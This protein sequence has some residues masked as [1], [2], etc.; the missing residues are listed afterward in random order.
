MLR[1]LVLRLLGSGKVRTSAAF[2]VGAVA[3]AVANLLFAG[4]LSP[5]AYGTLALVVAIIAAGVPI[6]PFGVAVVVVR[7][8]LS[9]ERSL[10]LRCAFT[11]TLVGFAVAIIA[12]YVYGLA[13]ALLLVIA[14]TIIGG[15]FTRIVAARLQSEER[16]LAS[17]LVS[18]GGNYVLLIAAVGTL[19]LNLNGALLPLAFVGISQLLLAA[20][21]AM[22]LVGTTPVQTPTH[23]KFPFWEML[24]L[25]GTNAATMVLLQLER[26]AIPVLLDVE[27]LATFAVLAVFT[28]APFRPVEVSTYRTLLP[29]LSRSNSAKQ[30]S[31][32]LLREARQAVFLFAVLG[33]LIAALTPVVVKL[34]FSGKYE[35][36]LSMTL[37]G[38][39]IGQL[40][41]VR[42][43]FAATIAALADPRGLAVWNSIAWISVVTTFVGGWIGSRW[44]LQGFLWGVALGGVLNAV[45][46]LPL[47][48][49]L[50]RR[51]ASQAVTAVG[52]GLRKEASNKR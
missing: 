5:G 1:N 22:R 18:E 3:F 20:I 50:L 48:V 6:A 12:G 30:R 34:M 52:P 14:F 17:T 49:S 36:T 15:G 10:M 11:S 42:S 47:V 13:P 40:R 37:A 25:T 31:R 26:F 45:L 29:R 35:F 32:L 28:M 38:I 41:V 27:M 4:H 2:L 23:P 7:K 19:T 8:H 24:L 43:M 16:F 39:V 33:V 44:A 21:L 51:G 9:L 46:T